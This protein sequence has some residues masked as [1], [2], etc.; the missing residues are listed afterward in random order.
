MKNY[1][2]LFTILF[3]FGSFLVFGQRYKCLLQLSNYKGEGAYIVVSL[4]DKNG[5]YEKTLAVLGQDKKWYDTLKEWN[6][7]QKVKKESLNGITSASVGGGERKMLALNLPDEYLDKGYTIRF[8]TAVENQKY[9]AID[10]V[11][12]FTSVNDTEKYEG[13]GYIRYVRLTK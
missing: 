11:I 12:P 3:L 13:K 1:K 5:K 6:K 9:Y 8:E 10:A 7:S 2:F 4:V